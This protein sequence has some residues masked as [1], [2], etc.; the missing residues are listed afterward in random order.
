MVK[1]SKTVTIHG[2]EYKTVAGRVNEFREE[3]KLDYS[4][5]SAIIA[6]DDDRVVMKAFIRDLNKEDRPIIAVGHAEELRNASTINRTSA[7]EN[8]ETSAY[9]RALAAFGF[10]G[11]EFASA[12]EVVQ[13]ISQQKLST[14]ERTDSRKEVWDANSL[15]RAKTM[16][17]GMF[18]DKGYDT[19]IAKLA[20][21]KTV[22]DKEV[23]ETEEDANLIADALENEE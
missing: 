15:V 1:E 8:C 22:L 2:K 5:E 6:I 9:G 17:N 10:A 13:A 3:Y 19:A 12:D 4:L 18:T 14:K 11:T 7:L 16:I 20:F 23:I 21:V